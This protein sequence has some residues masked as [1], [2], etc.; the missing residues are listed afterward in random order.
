MTTAAVLIIGDEIL[1]GKVRDSNG[2]LMIDLLREQGVALK[3]LVYLEDDP[4]SL[5]PEI[6]A[7]AR[8]HDVLVTSGGLGPTHDDRTIEAV[9]RAFDRAVVRSP[10]IEDMI[11]DHW[12]AR[13]SDTALRMADVPQGARLLCGQDLS[14]IHI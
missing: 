14:L 10:F 12:G 4:A 3:R 7:S 13:V 2:P 1:G 9:A 5:V 6:Q 8:A 11:R